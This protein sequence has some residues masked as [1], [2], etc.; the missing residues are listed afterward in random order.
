MS[1]GSSDETSSNE[2]RRN[3]RNHNARSNP[4]VRRFRGEIACRDPENEAT[5]EDR[6][7]AMENVVCIQW[8]NPPAYVKVLAAVPGEKFYR[9][10]LPPYQ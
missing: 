4:E 8:A 2:R 6:E 7:D 1:E 9:P 5:D 10:E 3:E